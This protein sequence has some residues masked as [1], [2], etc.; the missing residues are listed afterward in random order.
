MKAIGNHKILV[1]FKFNPIVIAGVV[2]LLFFTLACKSFESKNNTCLDDRTELSSDVH[3]V[4]LYLIKNFKNI[5]KI[6]SEL[7]ITN[8]NQED[9]LSAQMKS[10][11]DKANRFYFVIKF[12]KLSDSLFFTMWQQPTFPEFI[13]TPDSTVRVDLENT[14]YFEIGNVNLVILDFPESTG[15]NLYKNKDEFN[16]AAIK[17]RE[18]FETVNRDL[19]PVLT[20]R[21]STYQT[22]QMELDKLRR[23]TSRTPPKFKNEKELIIE[24]I[25]IN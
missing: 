21:E 4:I 10:P 15:H 9:Y 18:E 3:P 7:V 24:D 17:K 5:D 22:F 13:K 2:V 20:S 23:V 25:D 19:G 16:S 11:N 8:I 12:F 14:Y 6:N 1:H